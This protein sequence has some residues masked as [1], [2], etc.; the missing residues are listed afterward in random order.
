MRTFVFQAEL[1]DYLENQL[2]TEKV[3]YDFFA[4]TVVSVGCDED[5]F[6]EIFLAACAEKKTEETGL[7]H[8]TKRQLKK[9]GFVKD[10]L[11]K[12]NRHGFIVIDDP[13]ILE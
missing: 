4:D 10:A 13:R 12:Y 2:E 7:V 9:T 11:A 6:E 5:L 3:E 1:K 8:V